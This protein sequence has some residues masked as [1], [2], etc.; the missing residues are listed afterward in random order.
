MD[1]AVYAFP[2]ETMSPQ[3]TL[4]AIRKGMS[5]CPWG[6]AN[7]TVLPTVRLLTLLPSWKHCTIY[8]HNTLWSARTTAGTK[9]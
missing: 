7:T 1:S 9:P 8:S 3:S 5:M 6:H 4:M 2:L